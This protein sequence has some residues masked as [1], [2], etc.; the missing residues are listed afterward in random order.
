MESLKD[1]HIIYYI[2]ID[3]FITVECTLF[4]IKNVILINLTDCWVLNVYFYSEWPWKVFQL[5]YLLYPVL[6]AAIT[7]IVGVLVSFVTSTCVPRYRNKKPL[8]S[9]IHPLVRNMCTRYTVP[10]TKD[11]KEYE[12][13]EQMEN[14]NKPMLEMESKSSTC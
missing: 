12:K 14:Q 5:S 6:A 2:D 10:G 4:I 11:Y 8:S 1:F 3:Y 9:L 13:G 7:I